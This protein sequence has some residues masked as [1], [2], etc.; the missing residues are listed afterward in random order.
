MT[1]TYAPAAEPGS[2]Q[3]RRILIV[4]DNRD[5]A[6]SL[7]MLLQLGGCE[8]EMA[9]DGLSAIEV[10]ASFRPDVILMDIGLPGIDGFEAA[11]RIRSEPWGKQVMLIAVTGWAQAEDRERSRQAGFDAHLV[12]PVDH[13]ALMKLLAQPRT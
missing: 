6:T 5:A 11:Q 3:S 13:A 4:D 2:A 10:G 12:K 1:Q 9:F 7:G 8:T